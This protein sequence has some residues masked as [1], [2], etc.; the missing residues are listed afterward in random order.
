MIALA[1]A[2]GLASD[3]TALARALD[4]V[5]IAIALFDR[6]LRLVRANERFRILTG[7]PRGTPSLLAPHEIFPT[8]LA[9]IGPALTAAWRGEPYPPIPVRFSRMGGAGTTAEV[10]VARLPDALEREE[11]TEDGLLFVAAELE[12]WAASEWTPRDAASDA[13]SDAE[14]PRL[15][16]RRVDL[17]VAPTMTPRSDRV[18]SDRVSSDRVSGARRVVGASRLVRRDAVLPPSTREAGGEWRVLPREIRHD[19]A[20]VLDLIGNAAHLLTLR[21][22]DPD[23][24]RAYAERIAGAV[25]RGTEIIRDAEASTRETAARSAPSAR[26]RSVNAGRHVLVVEDDESSRILMTAILES[27][28]HQVRAVPGVTAALE[29]LEVHAPGTG[30]VPEIEV[31]VTDVGLEDGS[32]WELAATARARWPRLRV[33]V[34]TGWD[35]ATDPGVDTDFVLRKPLR[36][37]ELLACVAGEQP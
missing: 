33:G 31:L 21:A 34:V 28:G 30:G 5:P 32:G 12:R 17:A 9:A 14:V 18:S 6:E 13:A 27:R 4:G 1:E 15:V 20:N 23:A 7:C 11:G 8:S 26:Q 16:S 10:S 36:L 37:P 2:R 22:A 3:T 29:V 24:V 19:L 35:P 25:Q